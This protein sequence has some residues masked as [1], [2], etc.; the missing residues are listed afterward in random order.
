MTTPSFYLK[1]DDELNS[2]ITKADSLLRKYE[3][4][5][6]QFSLKL[7]VNWINFLNAEVGPEE[8]KS[9]RVKKDS[10]TVTQFSTYWERLKDDQKKKFSKILISKKY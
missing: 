3:I 5:K 6:R 4:Q 9:K 7:L 8:R 1:T 10:N 2:F